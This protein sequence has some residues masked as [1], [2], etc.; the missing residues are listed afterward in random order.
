MKIEDY[1]NKIL[2]DN[3]D[4]NEILKD[5][6]DFAFD[7]IYFRYTLIR[8]ELAVYKAKESHDLEKELRFAH[9]D[10]MHFYNTLEQILK[11]HQEGGSKS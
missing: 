4:L 7:S 2:V 8:N 9:N 5:R 10:E 1:K 3:D 6:I 11:C